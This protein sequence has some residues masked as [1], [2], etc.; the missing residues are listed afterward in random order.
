MHVRSIFLA[1]VLAVAGAAGAAGTATTVMAAG[2][3]IKMKSVD[4]S[5]SGPF[6][7]F[8]RAQ[9]KRGWKVFAGVCATCHGLKHVYYRHLLTIGI[10][11]KLMKELM[12]ARQMP[13]ID[14][15]GDAGTRG[16]RMGDPI[17]S[18]FP[19]DIAASKANN[20]RPPPDLSLIVKARHGGATYV[21]NLLVGYL[22]AAQCTKK[23]KGSDGKPLK[24]GQGQACNTYFP[25][26]IIAMPPPLTEAGQVDYDGKGA[27]K[28]TVQQMAMDVTAFLAWTAE[29]KMEDRKRMGIRVMLFLLILTGLF[30]AI[31]RQVWRRVKH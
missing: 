31:Y 22:S 15:A 18:P 3:S 12:E 9:I 30:F 14:D 2:D 26:H 29:P 28:A 1:G 8:D 19:N 16:A 4:W 11:P 10:E 6:G 24:P 5:F 25:G 27:P 21:Y 20:G 7:A 13:M 23:F 17:I